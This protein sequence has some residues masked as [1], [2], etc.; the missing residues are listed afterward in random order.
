MQINTTTNLFAHI[1]WGSLT[2]PGV[3]GR[4]QE[5]VLLGTEPSEVSLLLHGARH[6]VCHTAGCL[7]QPTPVHVMGTYCT[8]SMGCGG[9]GL[10]QVTKFLHL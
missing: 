2:G 10:W 3:G 9:M 8:P 7:L 5:L 4:A 6:H 1:R